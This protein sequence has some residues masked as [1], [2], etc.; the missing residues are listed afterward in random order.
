MHSAVAV[1]FTL[2]SKIEKVIWL[3][4]CFLQTID[5]ILLCWELMDHSVNMSWS[6]ISVNPLRLNRP[7]AHSIPKIVP[8]RFKKIESVYYDI[9]GV[10]E[11]EQENAFPWNPDLRS[12]SVTKQNTAQ[13][14][15]RYF[16]RTFCAREPALPWTFSALAHTSSSILFFRTFSL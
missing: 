5:P 15:H 12:Y 14:S 4:I 13:K 8:F 1:N 3:D 6:R 9:D 10:S 2:G 7:E 16:S 11:Y